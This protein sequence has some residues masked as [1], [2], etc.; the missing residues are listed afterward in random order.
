[1]A[2]AILKLP[3]RSLSDLNP[4]LDSS[5]HH[6]TAGGMPSAMDKFEFKK[7]ARIAQA[8]LLP[9]QESEADS[10]HA[11]IETVVNASALPEQRR[12]SLH[13]LCR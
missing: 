10:L 2:A 13:L 12:W 3:R 4:D 8:W 6:W 7:M 11:K 9:L 5:P 1:M